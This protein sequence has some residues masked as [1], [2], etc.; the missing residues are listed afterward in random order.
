MQAGDRKRHRFN[1]GCATYE[2]PRRQSQEKHIYPAATYAVWMSEGY[3]EL[4]LLG[5]KF[6]PS[7]EV[8]SSEKTGS[9]RLTLHKRFL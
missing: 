6:L 8:S 5:V 3:L 4:E 2:M 9:F 1:F 7:H